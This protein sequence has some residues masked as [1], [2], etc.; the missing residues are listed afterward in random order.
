M[1]SSAAA[2]RLAKYVLGVFI[3]IFIF[4]MDCHI[5]IVVFGF[6]FYFHFFLA[7]PF[8]QLIKVPYSV[9]KIQD[10]FMEKHHFISWQ[11]IMCAV[12]TKSHHEPLR[13]RIKYPLNVSSF[14]RSRIINFLSYCW[15]VVL[16]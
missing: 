15:I 9:F 10:S 16:T 8:L 2:K 5:F 12:Y 6:P 11:C 4:P 7:F 3:H 14:D 1:R 13:T